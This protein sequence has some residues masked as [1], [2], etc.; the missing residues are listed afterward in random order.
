MFRKYLILLISGVFICCSDGDNP[1]IPDT[2]EIVIQGYLYANKPVTHIKITTLA[3]Y[4]KPQTQKPINNALVSLNKNGLDYDLSLSPGDSGYYTYA[5]GDLTVLLGDSFRL[6]VTYNGK[7]ASATTV[8]PG[9]PEFTFISSDTLWHQPYYKFLSDS[10]RI[11]FKWTIPDTLYSKLILNIRPEFKS[12]WEYTITQTSRGYQYV[13]ADWNHNKLVLNYYRF[14]E[15]GSYKVL[16]TRI[17]KEY[18]YFL[19]NMEIVNGKKPDYYS[20][21]L[22]GYGIFTAFNSDSCRIYFKK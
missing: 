15:E 12:R 21:V 19:N 10:N 14:Y 1:I 3:L 22:N 9:A 20:N 16:L 5:G 17:N 4:D 2:D 18:Y 8:V 6:N 7:T 11:T 13:D